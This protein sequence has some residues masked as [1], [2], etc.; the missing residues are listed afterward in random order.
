MQLLPLVA[1]L[2]TGVYRVLPAVQ[3]CFM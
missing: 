3:V 2:H 1:Q